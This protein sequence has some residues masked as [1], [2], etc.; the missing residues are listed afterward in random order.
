[1][2]CNALTGLGVTGVSSTIVFPL[3]Q[4][5]YIA[6]DD[7]GNIYCFTSTYSRLQVYNR[8]GRFV[9]GWFV[10]DPHF[11]LIDSSD[12]TL[13]IITSEDKRLVYNAKG[14]LINILEEEK[15]YYRKNWIKH[16]KSEVSDAQGNTYTL[17]STHFYTTIVR[18]S[19]EGEKS[20]IVSDPWQLWLLRMP[21]PVLSYLLALAV[22]WCI[23]ATL[24][25]WKQKK[26]EEKGT[27]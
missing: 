26:M 21:D 14:E 6:L 17:G 15:G 25:K 3:G 23:P 11:L 5:H 27:K 16:V 24:K 7:K 20:T 1:M 8:T 12:D 18:I 10:P 19:P 2:T 4:P 9:R 22:I 13:N